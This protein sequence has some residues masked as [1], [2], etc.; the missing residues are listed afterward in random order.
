MVRTFLGIGGQA[1]SR[2]DALW[3]FFEQD[4]CWNSPLLYTF[5]FPLAPFL[6]CNPRE[7]PAPVSVLEA[8]VGRFLQQQMTEP[9]GRMVERVQGHAGGQ[10]F[11]PRS[12]LCPFHVVSLHSFSTE[13]DDR[14]LRW[15]SSQSWKACTSRDFLKIT[16]LSKL[17]RILC[18][19]EKS[20]VEKN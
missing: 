18:P 13:S 10:V 1:Q 12:S 4:P 8:E 2:G 14:I 20:Y 16:K 6:G 19:V 15:M 3:P 11:H 7:S 17:P 5:S 9:L